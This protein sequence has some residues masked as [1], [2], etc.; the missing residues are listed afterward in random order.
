MDKLPDEKIIELEKENRHPRVTLLEDALAADLLDER[1]L[2]EKVPAYR[3]WLYRLIPVVVAQ[4]LEALI[5]QRNYDVIFTQSEQAGLPLAF[6][7][8]YLRI[9]TPHVMI[10]SRIT[11]MDEKKSKQ[12]QW[13]LKHTHEAIDRILIWSSVQRRLAID[14]LGVP[15]QK[16]KLLKRGTDQKFWHP[17][18]SETDMICSVGMEMRDYPTLVEALRPLDI[19]CH[20]AAGAARGMIFETV[21]RL[22]DID[23]MP[24]NITVGKKSYEKLRRM[25]SRCRFTVVSL[26]P[27]DSDNGLTALLES[28]A[29][30]RPVIC[31]QAE[32]QVDV[33]EDGVTG[34]YVPVGDPEA[35]REAIVDLWNDPNRA[36]E[37]GKR[38]RRHIEQH[39]TMDQFVKAIKNEV[40]SV[41]DEQPIM[42]GYPTKKIKIEA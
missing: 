38:A 27:T 40:Q 23:K 10:I 42:N 33:I 8:K 36:E 6:L 29:M 2:F 14:K 30:G 31:S 7:M 41:V 25:Y 39:H 26:L 13:L 21:R 5:L 18:P 16:I 11:S 24:E 32:G 4:V 22:Y 19:P 3:R 17:I 35:L 20:I 1:Y 37:M 34:I 28:M 12:K 9:D 15:E